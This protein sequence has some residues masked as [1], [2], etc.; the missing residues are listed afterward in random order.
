MPEQAIKYNAGDK[1]RGFCPECQDSTQQ[2]LKP[3][4]P[5]DPNSILVWECDV[6]HSQTEFE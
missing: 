3:Y 4:D 1:S 6:C 2:T 5:D